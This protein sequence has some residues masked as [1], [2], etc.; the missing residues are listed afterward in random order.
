MTKI[1]ICGLRRLE[2]VEA[3]NRAKPDYAGFVFW[4][5]SR[6]LVSAET[7]LTL[8]TA[9]DRNIPA[10]GV[11]VD[12][13]MEQVLMLLK[14]GIINIAQLHGHETPEDIK[15][16]QQLSDR[17][18]WKAFKV[19]SE[20]DLLLAEASPA[21]LVL[22]DNGYGTGRSFDWGL[23]SRPLNRPWLLAG[24]LSPANIPQ[25]VDAF[26]P[27]GVDIS[28]G[29]ETDGQKDPEKIQAAVAAARR[30]AI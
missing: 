9:L 25:A 3:V 7:A 24:G 4:P 1:K 21:D 6:R 20:E 19:R 12:Q 23:L 18:V 10:V 22:L 17:P 11:F 8:R 16:L 30:Q 13:P 29:V 5:K 14:A 28:S 27:W 2:D 26:H 15:L